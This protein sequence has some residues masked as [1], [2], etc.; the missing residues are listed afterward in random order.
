M[1]GILKLFQ[2]QQPSSRFAVK[3]KNQLSGMRVTSALLTFL[4][5][6]VLTGPLSVHAASEA[7]LEETF[8][9][10]VRP[11]MDRY[12][13]RCHG[14]KKQKGGINFENYENFSQIKNR[15]DLWE[16]A[17][18]RIQSYEM[19]PEGSKQPDYN[20]FQTMMR[21]M[22]SL[23]KPEI[24]CNKLASDRTQSYY[25]GY[26]MSRRLTREEYGNSLRDLV[27]V[28]LPVSKILPKDGAGGEGF[29]TNGDT[30]FTSPLALERYMEC[31]D[32]ALRKLFPGEC[33]MPAA[34]YS[35][36]RAKIMTVVPGP[37]TPVDEAAKEI[38]YSF[39]RKAFRRTVDDY[40][41]ERYLELFE[42]SY[43]RRGSFDDAIRLALNG[44][45]LSPNFLF[46]AEPAPDEGG[47]HPLAP[48]PLASR[49]SYFI[50]ASTPDERLL[51]LAESGELLKE[52]VY[53][54][55]IYRMLDDPKARG[56]AER[57]AMQWLE[58]ESL[59]EASKLDPVR[60][61][62]FTPELIEE[63]KE[64]VVVFFH[65]LFSEDRPVT[66][67]FDADY[68]FA[69]PQLA[70]IYGVD[71]PEVDRAEFQRVVFE[72]NPTRGGVLGM[73][74]VHAATSYPLRT[75]PVLRGKW[76]LESILGDRIP[77]PPPN[78]PALEVDDEKVSA[79]SL[80]EQLELHRTQ[81]DCAACHNRMDPLGFGMENFDPLGRWRDSMEGAEINATGTLP[82]GRTFTGPGELKQVLME[83]KGKALRHMV[84]KMVGYA[85]GRSLNKFDQCVI[86]DT[87][88]ALQS[89]DYRASLMVETIATSYAF[90]HRYYPKSE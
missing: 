17:K 11:L 18:E 44:I 77:P 42:R 62:E 28:S 76:I 20:Q 60:F 86:D 22:R 84:K 21:W 74:A 46:L 69:G 48:F 56:L 85:F 55:E 29:D 6:S 81:P 34:K 53:Q 16:N 35:D 40:E 61:P 51:D 79:A 64:E 59:G 67:L 43:E 15:L 2:S 27:G 5:C 1:T 24:D 31:A 68:T 30:L 41:M 71:L 33:E 57:F 82:S 4:C 8:S 83:Q 52:D 72:N 78:V 65:H 7:E 12:C 66:E 3:F 75:S 89:N 58:L 32:T 45:L 26:V 23:P 47:V 87:M 73:A 14:E 50:W 39:A 54:S 88:E 70:Q 38:V 49:L 19:P 80:R 25:R 13:F 36:A 10:E 37:D 9:K 90:R 63:M